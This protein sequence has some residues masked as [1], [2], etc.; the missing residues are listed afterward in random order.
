M[1]SSDLAVI[2]GVDNFLRPYLISKG[3][4]MPFLLVF[5]GVIGG[6]FTFGI[7]GIFLGPTLL[8]LAAALT[9]EW[10]LGVQE[11]EEHAAAAQIDPGRPSA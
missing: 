10:L 4:N 3:S 2:S 9:R 11:E 7:L 5:M 1:C 6:V 8:A